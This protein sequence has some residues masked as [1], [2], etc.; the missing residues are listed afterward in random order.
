M[1][2]K[3]IGLCYYK[4]EC[5]CT[6]LTFR[7]FML[8]TLPVAVAMATENFFHSDCCSTTLPDVSSCD[9]S[10]IKKQI[11]KR[12]IISHLLLC[13]DVLLCSMYLCLQAKV[14]LCV[15]AAVPDSCTS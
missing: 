12:D 11:N 9:E 10:T 5:A 6:S 7:P 1:G 8:F 14:I 15:R 13:M 2:P 3:P 4:P